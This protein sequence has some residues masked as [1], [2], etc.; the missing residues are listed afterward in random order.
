MIA[1]EGA[2]FGQPEVRL[3]I[4]PGGGGTQL[5]SRRI[6]IGL[7]RQLLM[8]GEL[9]DAETAFRVGLVNSLHPA[10][11]L[12]EAAIEVATRIATS[13][14]AAVACVRRSIDEGIGARLEEAIEIELEQYRLLVDHPDRYEGITAFNGRRQPAFQDPD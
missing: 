1:A 9:V 13:S 14:P 10:Q 7:A 8:T 6:P 12:L 5:L 2:R 11:K 4:M 3:G